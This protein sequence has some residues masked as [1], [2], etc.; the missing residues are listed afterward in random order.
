MVEVIEKKKK[1]GIKSNTIPDVLIYEHW[2]GKPV[3]YQGYRDV[4]AG[5]KQPE[6]I[7]SCSDVQSALIALI[8]GYLFNTIDRKQYMIRTNEVGLNLS[9]GNNLGIDIAIS[10]RKLTEKLSRNY[11]K[12]APQVVIEV[13][14]KAEIEGQHFGDFDYILKKSQKLIDSGTEN[15]I[16]IMTSSR[17]VF[18]ISNDE[19][20][21]RVVKWNEDIFLLDNHFLN[22]KNLLDEEGIEV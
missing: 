12:T 17:T 1:S 3:Y 7:M 15:V 6:E 4:I 11:L 19:D 2:N 8:V 20:E 21:G 9:K 5:L 14:I 16:W 10:Q 13:D 22:I 18:V